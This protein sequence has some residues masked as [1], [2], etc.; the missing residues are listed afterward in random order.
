MD[1]WNPIDKV[2]AIFYPVFNPSPDATPSRLSTPTPIWDMPSP[3]ANV[4]HPNTQDAIPH[5]VNPGYFEKLS[6]IPEHEIVHNDPPTW[7]ITANLS[8]FDWFVRI[9]AIGA[10]G[11][12]FAYALHYSKKA[13]ATPYSYFAATVIGLATGFAVAYTESES[14]LQGYLANKEDVKYWRD[15]VQH[16]KLVL[17]GKIDPVDEM[18]M[19][20]KS[21][22]SVFGPGK[23][24]IGK[25]EQEYYS[26]G[27]NNS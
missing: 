23:P 19:V 4:K 3:Y 22:H 7:M 11:P 25:I 17:D 27:N 13:K 16:D 26:N 15:R 18:S 9:P 20:Q 24:D 8:K 21:V 2:W 5:Y 10:T 6:M 1:N 14:R 12:A